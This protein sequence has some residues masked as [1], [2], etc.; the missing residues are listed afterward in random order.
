DRVTRP[1]I[2]QPDLSALA[3]TV[4]SVARPGDLVLT[5][6]AGDITMQGPEI[7]EALRDRGANHTVTAVADGVGA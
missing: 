2:F 5:L 6:G 4:A 3:R 1:V 7:L